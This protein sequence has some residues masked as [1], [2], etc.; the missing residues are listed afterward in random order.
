L[1]VSSELVI[2]RVLRLFGDFSSAEG[3][4]CEGI[5]TY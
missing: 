1:D 5:M 4:S 2:V 3:R